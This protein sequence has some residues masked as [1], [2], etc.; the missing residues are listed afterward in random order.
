MIK[1]QSDDPDVEHAAKVALLMVQEV[2]LGLP[3]A[4]TFDYGGHELHIGEYD[5]CDVCTG[6]I[7]EAQQ[8]HLALAKKAEEQEDSVIK[9]HLMLAAKLFKLESEAAVVRA[10]F[11]NGIG[12]EPI[13]NAILGFQYDRSIHDDYKHSH[14]QGK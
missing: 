5:V 11:H 6:P 7:A 3:K 4:S 13:L 10:E 9:E 8:A 12:T 14:G 1:K 2:L